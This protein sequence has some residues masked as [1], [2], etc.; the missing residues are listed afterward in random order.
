MLICPDCFENSS[1]Q[2][3]IQEIRPRFNEGKCEQHPSKK[4]V[5]I[6]EVAR[7]MDEVIT[8][9]YYVSGVDYLGEPTGSTL[10]DLIYDLT[11]ADHHDVATALQ[12]AIIDNETW[13]P[14]DGGEPFFSEEN[15]YD[16]ITEV[17]DEQRSQ[18][19][20]NFRRQIVS[21]QRFFND[22]A[23]KMLSEIFDGLQLLRDDRNE[24]AIRTLEPGKLTIF[25]ARRA[26]TLRSQEAISSN[27]AQ[28]LG[29]P[30]PSLRMPG[31]MNPSGIPSFY[32]AFDLETALAELRPAVGETVMAAQFDLVRPVV[33][34]DTTKFERPPKA[35][36]IFAKTYNKRLSLWGFM[37]EFMNEISQ[38]CLPGDEHLDYIPTQVVAE[39]L[40]HLH[41]FK[42][43]EQERT[44]EGII[45]R[46]AQNSE[47]KNI[48]LFG[49][50]TKVKADQSP[51]TGRAR[52]KNRRPHTLEVVENSLTTQIIDS[53]Q[54]STSSVY[55]GVGEV[56]E[57]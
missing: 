7:I 23:Q 30:P 8:N 28:E 41:R 32:G 53:V 2:N 34:L 51:P 10:L 4:G 16:R 11:G 42:H 37:A 31:R 48:V 22:S 46:S 24:P 21:K 3:R 35:L 5:P 43:N 18:M 20:D 47:G 55:T 14:S 25:R 13:W 57:F 1:L 45:F 49:D 36:N 29:P 12:N 33:V 19:W 56:E 44:V 15:G 6:E 38:P 9:N 26:N 17:F 27:V 54:V 40:V 39:Y 50:A 52:R